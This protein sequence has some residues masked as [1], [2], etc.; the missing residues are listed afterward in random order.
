VKA[1]ED[2]KMTVSK[3]ANIAKLPAEKQR[4][5]LEGERIMKK[6]EELIL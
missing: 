6:G 3:A 5:A 4:K 2:G 1:V